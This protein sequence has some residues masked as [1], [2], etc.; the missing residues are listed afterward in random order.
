[1]EDFL[2]DEDPEQCVEDEYKHKFKPL[3]C[4]RFLRFVSFLD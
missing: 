2:G 4:W 3:Y 1:M